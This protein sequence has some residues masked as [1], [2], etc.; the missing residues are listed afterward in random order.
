MGQFMV[1]VLVATTLGA[2]ARD[3][4]RLAG[5]WFE[6]P[7]RSAVQ[8]A[9]RRLAAPP[10][11]AVLSDFLDVRGRPLRERLAE[12][13]LDAPSHARSIFFYD[14]SSDAPCRRPGVYAFTIPGSRI[15]RACPLLGSLAASD[16]E[17][18]E[19]VVIHEVLHTLGLEEDALTSQQ[20][21]ARVERRCCP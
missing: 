14:G 2:P 3:H 17:R 8:G 6:T 11:A 15:V 18:A 7:V 12:L 4:V 9:A 21:T 1:A 5:R 10:C 19:A 20:I 13:G 16:P